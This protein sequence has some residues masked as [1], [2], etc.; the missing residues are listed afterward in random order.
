MWVP[1]LTR[2]KSYKTALGGFVSRISILSYA[3]F[4]TNSI[5][6]LTMD[7]V[8]PQLIHD[9]SVFGLLRVLAGRVGGFLSVAHSG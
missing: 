4:L 7:K 3:M 9:H 6:V 2:W 5:T 1:L 8:C